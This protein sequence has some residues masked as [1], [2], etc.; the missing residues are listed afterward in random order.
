MLF[1]LGLLLLLPAAAASL[2]SGG[3][4]R[5]LNTLKLD[6]LPAGRYTQTRLAPDGTVTVVFNGNAG[7]RLA[8]CADATC[9]AAT[10]PHTLANTD[11]NPRFIRMELDGSNPVMAYGATNDTELHLTRCH[12]PLCQGSTTAVLATSERVRHCDLLLAD[13][14]GEAVV[15]VGLSDTHGST[16]EQGSRLLL[17]TS[18]RN[19]TV[20]KKSIATDPVPFDTNST[21]GLPTGGLEMPCLIPGA[22]PDDEAHVAYWDVVRKSLNVVFEATGLEPRTVVAAK[23]FD[24]FGAKSSPGAWVRAVRAP[25]AVSRHKIAVSYFDLPAGALFT[26]ICDEQLQSCEEEE[27]KKIDLVGH[28]DVSDFGA[29]AFP[30]FRQLSGM[31]GPVLAYF[32]EVGTGA[33]E[34]GLLKLLSCADPLCANSSVATLAH[35]H[36]GF[37]RDCSLEMIGCAALPQPA[38]LTA[39]AFASAQWETKSPGLSTPLTFHII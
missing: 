18:Q 5:L 11:P 33:Q 12:D 15:A 30:E 39:A 38:T 9:S 2:S 3:G 4:W 17:I 20:T 24:I 25:L 36:K 29:G 23:G 16:A 7:L 21:T 1:A 28:R 10:P 8:R 26:L 13:D 6:P 14:D 37:G 35:G 19:G 31:P 27:P 34:Q 22:T 32:S